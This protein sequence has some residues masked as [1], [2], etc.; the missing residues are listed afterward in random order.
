M[1]DHFEQV[2]LFQIRNSAD[3]GTKFLHMQKRAGTM[4]GYGEIHFLVKYGAFIRDEM[5]AFP[6]DVSNDAIKKA[7]SSRWPPVLH[8]QGREARE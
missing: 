2:V 8:R 6:I 7:T 3:L 1:L 5:N 4:S